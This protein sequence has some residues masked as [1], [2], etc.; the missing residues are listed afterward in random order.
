MVTGSI[1]QITV[2]DA[3]E[4]DVQALTAIKQ[5]E[6]IHKDRLQEALGS[7]FRYLVLLR[8]PEVI[9]FAC[10]VFRRPSSWSDAND[11]QHLPQVVDL[12]VAEGQRGRGYG[13]AF[14]HAIEQETVQAGYK[15][16]YLAVEPLANARVY[17]LYERLGYRPLQPEPYL[18]HWEFIDSSGDK[19]QGEQWIV[20]MVKP[21]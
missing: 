10:L 12:Q 1:P 9:G 11:R 19:H 2:R 5:P 3:A 20:D 16:L 8:G 15:Q 18:K 7:G 17:A 6:V 4:A 13:S 21:L 14:L